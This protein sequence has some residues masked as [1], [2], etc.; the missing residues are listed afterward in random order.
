M[1]TDLHKWH[2]DE[3][4]YNNDNRSK[5]GGKTVLHPG[6]QIRFVPGKPVAAE[7]IVTWEQFRQAARKWYRKIAK[8][9][10]HCSSSLTVS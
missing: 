3:T 8:V 2:E 9:G 6:F 5:M 1:L 7:D 10:G 4:S